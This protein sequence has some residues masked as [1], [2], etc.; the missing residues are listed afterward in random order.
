MPIAAI[1]FTTLLIPTAAFGDEPIVE[2]DTQKNKIFSTFHE[3]FTGMLDIL[4]QNIEKQIERQKE[5]KRIDDIIN[6][7]HAQLGKPYSWGACGPNSFD[8]SGLVSYCLSGKYT[9][10]GTTSTFMSWKR[11]AEPRPGDV[12][13]NSNHCGIYIGNGQ[14]IHA[15]HTG[16]VV[17]I[18]AVH[19]G[20]VY[21]RY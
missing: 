12:C 3:Q 2:T 17:K 8:C 11:T 10:L 9:R 4:Q 21:V 20:M 5:Q 1:L 16:D 6:R 13:V 15:P 19:T 18:S 7:A 14:M